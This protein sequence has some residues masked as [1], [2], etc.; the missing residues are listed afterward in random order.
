MFTKTA[1]LAEDRR[2]L[3][4]VIDKVHMLLRELRLPNDISDQNILVRSKTYVGVVG[5]GLRDRHFEHAFLEMILG[6]GHVC[7]LV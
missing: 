5:Q 4:P 7:G 3:G 6:F 1:A 2:P